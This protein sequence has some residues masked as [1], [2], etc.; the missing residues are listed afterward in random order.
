MYA[1]TCISVFV[2]FEEATSSLH[3]DS[4]TVSYSD[5]FDCDLK[6]GRER[7]VICYFPGFWI[8]IWQ[9]IFEI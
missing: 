6:F 4:I 8:G 7:F 2:P 3:R 9:L 1:F 5:A